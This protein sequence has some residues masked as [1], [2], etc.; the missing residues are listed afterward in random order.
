MIKL[1]FE[2]RLNIAKRLVNEYGVLMAETAR[3]L[4]VTTSAISKTIKR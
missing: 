4:G 3:S 2:I 1:T